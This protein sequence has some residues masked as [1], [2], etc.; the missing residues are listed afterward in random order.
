M[1]TS[2]GKL[3]NS[4][5]FH[6]VSICLFIPMAAETRASRPYR[7]PM[8][9]ERLKE[10]IQPPWLKQVFTGIDTRYL[11]FQVDHAALANGAKG[12]EK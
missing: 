9:I 8:M 10:G 12:H 2:R 7:K 6:L 3:R 1:R 11:L 4:M 5:D